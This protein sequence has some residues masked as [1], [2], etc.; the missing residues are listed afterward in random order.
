V[1]D[2]CF[3]IHFLVLEAVALN[4]PLV[5][6]CIVQPRLETVHKLCLYDFTGQAAVPYIDAALNGENF[7]IETTSGLE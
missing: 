1:T 6:I 3:Y 2:D 4:A 5:C 7:L